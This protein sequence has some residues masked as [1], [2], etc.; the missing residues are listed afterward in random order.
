MDLENIRILIKEDMKEVDILIQERLQSDV[1]LINQL[2]PG[3][4]YRKGVRAK[5]VVGK[6]LPR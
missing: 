6:A 5:R 2:D 1:A 4:S 3:E